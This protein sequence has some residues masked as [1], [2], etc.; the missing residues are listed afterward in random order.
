LTGYFLHDA[1]IGVLSIPSFVTQDDSDLAD[2]DSAIA[3]FI[4]SSQAAGLKQIVIDLQANEG[5]EPLL[6]IDTFKHFFPNIDPFGGSRLRATTPANVLGQTLTLAF[7]NLTSTNDTYF[8]LVDSEWV[9]TTRINANTNHTFAS[10]P[11]FFGPSQDNG[12][13]F[14]TTQRYDLNNDNF[15][16]SAFGDDSDGNFTVFGYSSQSAASK[17]APPY[18]AENIIMVSIH[19][20][21]CR[22]K[23]T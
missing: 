14:T 5:G 8:Q 7:T 22:S 2:F 15:V 18:A 6:A 9:A 20:P 23:L 10:W 19:I 11:E 3:E 16:A 21:H 12:D 17:I 1:S 4:T 13:Y